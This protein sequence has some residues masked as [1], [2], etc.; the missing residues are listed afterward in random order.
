MKKSVIAIFKY[1]LQVDEAVHQLLKIGYSPSDIKTFSI[2]GNE[3]GGYKIATLGTDPDDRY[4]DMKSELFRS[5]T[6]WGVPREEAFLFTECVRHGEKL[7]VILTDEI[8]TQQLIQVL[9]RYGAQDFKARM[10][11]SEEQRLNPG[12]GLSASPFTHIAQTSSFEEER[13]RWIQEHQAQIGQGMKVKIFDIPD[14]R[15]EKHLE[16][17]LNE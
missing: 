15:T 7:V 1:Q 14:R 10:L 11:F 9:E 5:L 8:H 6:N 2:I 12:D 17:N 3:R 4:A 13:A 16:R